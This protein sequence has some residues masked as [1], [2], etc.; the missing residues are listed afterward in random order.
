MDIKIEKL[1]QSLK[2]K[3]VG[4]FVDDSNLYHSYKKYGWR[5]DFGKLRNLLERYCDL[6]FIN[7]H[8]AIPAK[9]DDVFRGTEIFLQKISPFVILKKKLLKYTPVAGKFMKKADTDVEITLDVVRNIDNL[10]VVIIVSGDSDFLELK[11]YVVRDKNK[12]ILFVGYEENMAWE[13]RQC[14]HLYVNRIKDE[15]ALQ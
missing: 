6:Q 12:N 9:S 3:R 2:G 1:L 10:D 8:I 11:N 14:W 7:Y 13:L 5:I 15:V 4:V